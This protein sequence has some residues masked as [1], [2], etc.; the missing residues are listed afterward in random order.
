M[1]EQ[2]NRVMVPVLLGSSAKAMQIARALY[3]RYDVV[4]HLYCA[5]PV[6][7]PYLLSYVRV[8]RVPSYMQGELLCRDLV[9]F[10]SEYPDLLFCLIPC[11]VQ[12]KAFCMA[13]AAEL[14]PYYIISEPEQLSRGTL[15]YLTKEELPT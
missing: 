15:S 5:R 4:S 7:L 12:D 6:I 14:E 2:L 9:S 8:V 10:A 13:H 3:L 11:T 1:K